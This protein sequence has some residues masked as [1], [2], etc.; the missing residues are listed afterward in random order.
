MQIG[1]NG[2]SRHLYGLFHRTIEPASTGILVAATLK[3][4]SRHFVAREILHT[5]QAHLPDSGLLSLLGQEDAQLD[6]L[7]LQRHIDKAFCIPVLGIEASALRI[8]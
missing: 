6:A 8:G 7:Y 5:S 1:L 2:L 3:D 4:L